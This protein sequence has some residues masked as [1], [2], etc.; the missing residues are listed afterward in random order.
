MRFL[1]LD[2]SGKI[3]P[4]DPSRFVVFA[5]FSVHE[6]RW[7]ALARQVAGAK[8]HFYARRGDPHAW[9]IKSTDLLN[10]RAWRRGRTLNFCYE[11]CRILRDNRCQVRA[12]L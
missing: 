12:D 6:S 10:H 8:A 7:H 2:D 3:H 9:E 4:N 11:I 1:Y 5:G